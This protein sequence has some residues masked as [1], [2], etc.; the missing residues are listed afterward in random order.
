MCVCVCVCYSLSLSLSM[1]LYNEHFFVFLY[2]SKAV[3]KSFLERQHRHVASDET[4]SKKMKEGNVSKKTKQMTRRRA[5]A[6]RGEEHARKS[7][8][9]KRK[10]KPAT[11][12]NNNRAGIPQLTSRFTSNI[13]STNLVTIR[14]CKNPKPP[15]K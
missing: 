1:S 8:R 3:I 9:K 13:L 10:Q 5:W 4:K 14:C 15:K 2:Q 7:E 12:G 11:N 6:R